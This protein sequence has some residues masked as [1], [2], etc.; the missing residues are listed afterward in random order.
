MKKNAIAGRTNA[1]PKATV[2]IW[3]EVPLTPAVSSLVDLLVEMAC[4]RVNAVVELPTTSHE[5]LT[6]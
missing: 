2:P 4:R 5:T 6:Q 3:A 1:I